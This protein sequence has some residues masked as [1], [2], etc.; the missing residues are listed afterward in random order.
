MTEHDEKFICRP[1]MCITSIINPCGRGG[2][3]Y[4]ARTK[5]KES[6]VWWETEMLVF[7]FFKRFK[8]L[9]LEIQKSHFKPY[10]KEYG[11]NICVMRGFLKTSAEPLHSNRKKTLLLWFQYP[12]KARNM[13]RIAH[14][15]SSPSEGTIYVTQRKKIFVRGQECDLCLHWLHIS[16]MSLTH[17]FV[18]ILNWH[19]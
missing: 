17:T 9:L 13:V 10:P 4:I 15:R 6:F 19:S 2:D 16:C 8:K 5:Q 11:L 12:L 7:R 1:Q 3:C 14:G 18:I